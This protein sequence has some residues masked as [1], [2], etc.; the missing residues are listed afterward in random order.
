MC[1]AGE[2]PLKARCFRFTA[3]ASE[4]Y[5]SYLMTPPFRTENGKVVCDLFWKDRTVKDEKKA[6]NSR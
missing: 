2:C 5:Q 6:S 3:K 1:K 4:T